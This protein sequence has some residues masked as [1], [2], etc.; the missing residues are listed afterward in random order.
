MLLRNVVQ[1]GTIVGREEPWQYQ[2]TYSYHHEDKQR[3]SYGGW[4]VLGM[5]YV[6]R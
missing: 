2:L 6:S 1:Y 3:Q 5:N 4:H